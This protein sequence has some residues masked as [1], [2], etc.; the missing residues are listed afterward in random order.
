M[1]IFQVIAVSVFDN[2]AGVLVRAFSSEDAAD[3]YGI[4]LHMS[5]DYREVTVTELDLDGEAFEFIA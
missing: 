5:G 3:T 2:E 1:K 4:H